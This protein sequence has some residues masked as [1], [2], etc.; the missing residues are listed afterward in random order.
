M[1]KLQQYLKEIT[2]TPDIINTYAEVKKSDKP[3]VDDKDE[4]PRRRE[5]AS[6]SIVNARD[7][8]KMAVKDD[9]VSQ[10]EENAVAKTIEIFG[11]VINI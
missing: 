6:K 11:R 9:L 4:N 2:F 3:G 5:D 1:L 10:I 8:K 7:P